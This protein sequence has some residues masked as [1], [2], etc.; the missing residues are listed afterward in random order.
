MSFSIIFSSAVFRENPRDCYSLGVVIVV[1]QRLTFCNISFVTEDIY[2]LE[3]L[4]MCSL[5]KS[6]PHYQ[7]RQFKMHIFLELSPFFNLEKL[8]F[9]NISII[10]EDNYL[11]LGKCVHYPKSNPYYQGRQFKI[12]LFFFSQNHALFFISDF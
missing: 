7:G 5:S 6:S 3:T 4:N 2:I 11:K 1:V 9:C 12:F 8:T 10:T